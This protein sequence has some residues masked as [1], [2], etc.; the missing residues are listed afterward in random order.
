MEEHGA[1]DSE[2]SGCGVCLEDGTEHPL[3]V[4]YS[5]LGC[6][7]NLAPVRHLGLKTDDEGYIITDCKQQ[8]SENGIFAAGDIC[9]QIN[10]I[11][12]AFGQAAIA[13]VNIHNILDDEE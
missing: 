4:L 9:S 12:V 6:D 2:Y 5:A 13:A 10:Q 7:V 8:T 3:G 11:S 1:S